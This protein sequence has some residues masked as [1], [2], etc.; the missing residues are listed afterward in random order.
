MLDT[1]LSL[2][3]TLL[4]RDRF[5]VAL[6]AE[7]NISGQE[8]STSVEMTKQDWETLQASAE[9]LASS[10][11]IAKAYLASVLM[12]PRYRDDGRTFDIDRFLPGSNLYQAA[13]EASRAY[14]DDTSWAL[15]TRMQAAMR[16]TKVWSD[17]IATETGVDKGAQR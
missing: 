10:P 13:K 6:D 2:K 4:S 14:P 8:F 11:H 17:A 12:T 16:N 9:E 3:T 1:H 5:F 7:T 15:A